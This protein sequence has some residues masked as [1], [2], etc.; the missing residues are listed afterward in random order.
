LG[1]DAQ[2]TPTWPTAARSF[3]WAAVRTTAGHLVELGIYRWPTFEI[4]REDT[5]AIERIE[6]WKGQLLVIGAL[7]ARPIAPPPP[8]FEFSPIPSTNPRK[9]PGR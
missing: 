4:V 5:G 8:D 3:P 2:I 7:G 9:P 1:R 6:G